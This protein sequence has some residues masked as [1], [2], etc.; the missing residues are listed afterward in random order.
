MGGARL[1]IPTLQQL[2]KLREHVAIHTAIEASDMTPDAIAAVAKSRK[3]SVRSA[4]EIFAEMSTTLT[5]DR[6]GEYPIFEESVEDV[7]RDEEHDE[8]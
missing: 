8:Q 1:R 3:R 4:E 6:L 5:E 7:D 2:A